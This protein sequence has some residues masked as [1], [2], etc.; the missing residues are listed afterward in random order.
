VVQLVTVMTEGSAKKVLLDEATEV[1]VTPEIRTDDE[2]ILAML[3]EEVE[4]DPYAI[5]TG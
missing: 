1:P 3:R 2:V 5:G 4:L